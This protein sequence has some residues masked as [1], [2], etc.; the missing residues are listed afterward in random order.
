MSRNKSIFITL[1]MAVML[2]VILVGAHKFEARAFYVLLALLAGYGFLRG[3]GDLCHWMQSKEKPIPVIEGEEVK[4]EDEDPFAHDDEFA[5]T[6]GFAQFGFGKVRFQEG[7]FH[8][9][10]SD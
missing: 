4:I 6:E 5:E 8:G 2:A 1:V 7:E 3:S 9:E 10:E